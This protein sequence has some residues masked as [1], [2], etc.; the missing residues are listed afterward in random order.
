MKHPPIGV[1]RVPHGPFDEIYQ[2]VDGQFWLKIILLATD[3]PEGPR[4]SNP[5]LLPPGRHET[6]HPGGSS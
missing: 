2:R 6:G 5:P 4:A 1:G 3:L